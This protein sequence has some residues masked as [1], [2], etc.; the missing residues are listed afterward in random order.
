MMQEPQT[1]LRTQPDRQTLVPEPMHGCD[2]PGP[3]LNPTCAP[4]VSWIRRDCGVERFRAAFATH[5]ETLRPM[6]VSF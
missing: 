1:R 5:E 6:K 3:P 4:S 2:L